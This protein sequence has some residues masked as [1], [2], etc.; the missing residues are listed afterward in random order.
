ME[1][2]FKISQDSDGKLITLS[3]ALDERGKY[4][5]LF[6][7]L[8]FLIS[9]L[10]FGIALVVASYSFEAMLV[11][12]IGFIACTIA[13][14]RFGN[15]AFMSEKIFVNKQTIGLIRNGLFNHERK[16]YEISGISNF[17]PLS[18]PELTDHPLAG[19]SFDYLGFQTEQKVISEMHGDKGLAFDYEGRV[20]SFG[21]DIYSWQFDELEILLHDIS[22][23]DLKNPDRE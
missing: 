23:N 8:V 20:I 7:S 9:G 1:T 6:Y 16:D 12:A 3:R 2:I 5:Y 13:G 21:T 4:L 17:R 11:A 19:D 10:V 18:K 14:M 15:R 22:G